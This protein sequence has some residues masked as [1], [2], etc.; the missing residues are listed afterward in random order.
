M[1]VVLMI[2][3]RGI[4]DQYQLYL[5]S[6]FVNNIYTEIASNWICFL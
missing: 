1:G 6:H 4:D 5:L 2:D 3:G